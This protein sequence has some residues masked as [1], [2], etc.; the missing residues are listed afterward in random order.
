MFQITNSNLSTHHCDLLL[1]RCFDFRFRETDQKFVEEFLGSKN[2]DL[3]CLPAPAKRLLE[4][5]T[6]RALLVAD[7]Q[8]VCQGLHQVKKVL[9]LGHWDCGGYGGSQSFADA[10]AEEETYISDL[11]KAQALLRAALPDLPI[12]IGYSKIV[13]NNTLEYFL[14][15]E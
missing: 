2:F 12:L 3:T 15:T 8:K 5:E 7:I 9:L 10:Q 11:K 14:I 13:S 1:V 6:Q 4:N